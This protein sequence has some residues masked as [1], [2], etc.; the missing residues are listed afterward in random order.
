MILGLYFLT[1]FNFLL[2]P[3]SFQPFNLKFLIPTQIIYFNPFW[4]HVH[5]FWQLSPFF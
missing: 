1:V 4:I 2:P 5:P 3:P